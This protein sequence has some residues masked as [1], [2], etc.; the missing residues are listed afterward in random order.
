MF[1]ILIN[2]TARPGNKIPWGNLLTSPLRARKPID[3]THGKLVD[4]ATIGESI[5]M[6][7]VLTK[8]EK[9]ILD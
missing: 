5:D 3:M 2:D 4:D 8:T 9:K 7:K 6:E 1:I